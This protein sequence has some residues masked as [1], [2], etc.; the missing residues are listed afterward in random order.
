MGNVTPIQIRFKT[1]EWK[2]ENKIFSWTEEV[3]YHF[4]SEANF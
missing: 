3:I 2:I 1:A 4:Y